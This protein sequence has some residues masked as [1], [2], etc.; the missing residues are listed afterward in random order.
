MNIEE[1]DMPAS[2]RAHVRHIGH[3][4]F[5]DSNR[6]PVGNGHTEMGPVASALKEM[7]YEGYVS[8]EA[9]PWPGPDAAALQTMKA[10][11]QFFRD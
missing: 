5:A 10:F 7:G 3:V 1:A 9:F 11:K 2:I 6:R 8:A 4:H